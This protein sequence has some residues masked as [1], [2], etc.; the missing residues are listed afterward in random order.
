MKVLLFSHIQDIDGMGSV[1]LGKKAFSSLDYVLCKTFEV[2]DK[3]SSY[4]KEGKLY[5]YDFV[6]INDLCIKEPLLG[7]IDKDNQLRNKI[8]VFDHHITEIEEGNDKYNYV[9]IIVENDKGKTCGTSLFYDYLLENNYIKRTKTLDEFVELTRQHDTW[10]WKTKYNNPLARD[11]YVLF[12]ELGYE[13]YLDVMLLI[14]KNNNGVVFDKQEQKVIDEYNK[15]FNNDIKDI[16]ENMKPYSLDVNGEVYRI[17]FIRC[18]YKYRNDINEL[19]KENNKHDV[20]LVGMIFDDMD[21]VSYRLVKN[22]D[23]S[24][25]AVYFGGKGHKDA[26]SNLQNNEKFKIVLNELEKK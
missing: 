13:K 25:V 9:N 19:V 16:L 7:I 5:D 11:L 21:T 26:S 15:K 8:L 14:V 2:T 1:I 6:F 20:D 24:K 17:G 4:Y 3:V 10:E 23:A 12:G 22:K 18:P